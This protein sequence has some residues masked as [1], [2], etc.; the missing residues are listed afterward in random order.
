MAP[1]DAVVMP[2]SPVPATPIAP[3]LPGHASLRPRNTL[4][5]NFISLPAI[6]VPC[7]FTD[8]GLPIGLQVVG[9]A[10]DEAGVL[11][12]AA[13]YERA[14]PWRTRFPTL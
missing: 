12:V 6:S 9:K 3:G 5:F 2:T 11:R 14:T 1:Y 10:F 4:P 13:A 7:G 8:S